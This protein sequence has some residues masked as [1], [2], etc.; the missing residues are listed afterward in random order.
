MSGSANPCLL[1]PCPEVMP[2]DRA[3]IQKHRFAYE[4]IRMQV[5]VR[6]VCTSPSMM[7]SDYIVAEG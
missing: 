5:Q 3:Q 6:T 7:T 4:R 1:E 2:D